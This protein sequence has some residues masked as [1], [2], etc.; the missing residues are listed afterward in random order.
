M[1]LINKTKNIILAEDVLIA[2]TLFRRIKGLLGVKKFSPNQA[3]IL[4]PC[5]SVHT[6]FMHFSIDVIFVDRN[7]KVI[8]VLSKLSPNRITPI[9]W[10]SRKV[11][12]LSAGRLD[13]INIR[14]KD[15][16]QLLD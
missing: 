2:N 4:E 5:N 13:L 7:Y 6:F 11:I 1:R 15:Q 14:I 10:Y 9:Y 8:K 3:I 16:L 12:E